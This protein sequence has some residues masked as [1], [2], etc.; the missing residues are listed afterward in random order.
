MTDGLTKEEFDILCV[1]QKPLY[2]FDEFQ[3][4]LDKQAQNLGFDSH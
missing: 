2:T 4:V 3:Q 1:L